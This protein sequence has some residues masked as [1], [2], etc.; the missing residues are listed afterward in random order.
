MGGMELEQFLE[1]AIDIINK[2]IKKQENEINELRKKIEELKRERK[3]DESVLKVLRGESG[4]P[5]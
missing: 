3:I 2:K 5:R 1:K 4:E